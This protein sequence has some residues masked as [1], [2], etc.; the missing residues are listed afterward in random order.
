MA[1]INH[2]VLVGR[3][4][5]DAELRYAQSGLAICKFAVAVNRRRKQGDEW[6]DEANF[7]DVVVMGRQGEAIH[8]YLTKGKQVG[9]QGELR[10]DRWEQ[11]GQRRS[12]VEIH[13]FNVQLLGGS[14]GNGTGGGPPRGG[15]GGPGGGGGPQGGS[16]P[17]GGGQYGS[18]SS[19]GDTGE[20]FEDDI[21]F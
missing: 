11:D 15:S 4:T 21:P 19:A 5:R 2:V 9:V 18:Q 12:R 17:S 13:A 3:L 10:Q 8:Q 14:G 16:G 6:V 20:E 7:F 1:D